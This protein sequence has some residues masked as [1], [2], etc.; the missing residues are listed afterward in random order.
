VLAVVVFGRRRRMEKIGVPQQRM[1][2]GRK[3]GQTTDE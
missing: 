3:H 1:R 2:G